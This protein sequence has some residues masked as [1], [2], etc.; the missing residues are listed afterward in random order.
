MTTA[1]ALR[2]VASLVDAL[3]DAGIR[4]DDVAIDGDEDPSVDLTVRL[5]DASTELS[6]VLEPDV[7]VDAVDQMDAALVGQSSSETYASQ[8][9]EQPSKDCAEVED[10]ETVPCRVAS[11]DRLF[12]SAHGMKIHAA[13]AHETAEADDAPPHRDPERLRAAYDEHDTFAEM[14]DA[15]DTD[16]TAQTVRRNAMKLGIH[17]P[18]DGSTESNVAATAAADPN[19]VQTETGSVGGGS[20]EPVDKPESEG[21]SVNSEPTDPKKDGTES[22]DTPRADRESDSADQDELLT[23]VPVPDSLDD[24]EVALPELVDAVRKSRTLYEFQQALDVERSQATDVLE[25]FDLTDVVTGRA[26]VAASRTPSQ[27]EV[28]QRIADAVDATRTDGTAD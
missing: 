24:A 11:C 14:R 16:V 10:E 3:Q 22:S 19:A 21:E 5:P 28:E 15:L 27:E 18:D 17:D 26:E 9:D 1:D 13:K 4:V 23:G 8:D 20:A 7:E 6:R 2:D 25:T 12:D